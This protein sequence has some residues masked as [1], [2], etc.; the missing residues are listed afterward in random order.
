MIRQ[1]TFVPFNGGNPL[2]LGQ[3]D[4]I[5]IS[6]LKIL[7][8]FMGE[9]QTTPLERI[10]DVASLCGVHHIIEENVAIQLL[11]TYFRGKALQ[12]LR[13]LAINS[14]STWDDL[15]DDLN[16]KFEDKSNHLSLFEQLSTIKRAPQEH[17]TNFNF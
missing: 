4:D 9:D 11:E 17:M 14:S 1:H 13:G 15:G 8:I 7:P 5:L 16:R 6:I 12:W 10:K 3:Q 2:N